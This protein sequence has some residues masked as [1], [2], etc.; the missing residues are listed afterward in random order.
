MILLPYISQ[1]E[2][3]IIMKKFAIQ[4]LGE[5]GRTNDNILNILTKTLLSLSNLAIKVETVSA[6]NKIGDDSETVVRTLKKQ[7]NQTD[8]SP[9]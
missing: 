2:K 1:D 3:Y 9:L 5:I 4:A 7:F 8:E 6:L